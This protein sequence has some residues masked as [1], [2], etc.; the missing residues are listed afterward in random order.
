MPLVYE[1]VG[2]WA[3]ATGQDRHSFD[4]NPLLADPLNRDFHLQSQAGRFLPSGGWTND[5][6]SSPLIDAGWPQSEAWSS[7]PDPNGGWV[8]IGL[9]GG[10]LQA[11][12]SPTN[13]ALHLVSLNGGG[14]ASGPTL[15]S[16]KAAG[17]TTGHTVR[18]EVSSD[19]GATWVRIAEG[20]RADL[21]EVVWNS[22]GLSSSP[23]ALW[24]VQDEQQAGVEAV[25]ERNFT[26]HNDPIYYYVNDESQEGDLYCSAPGTS[27]NTGLSPASPRRQVADILTD[28]DLEP[29][30]V[31]YV[32]AGNYPW[33]NRL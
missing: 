10:T 22:L 8:N 26:I 21:G 29:G 16:W 18:L 13:A 30:D 9:Y 17:A 5:A 4:G 25:S 2:H 7:E 31:I 12:K 33:R 23:R 20:I 1:T 15:L 24:R 3:A 14:I 6:L 11:S 19:N 28:Y 27:G 32:D